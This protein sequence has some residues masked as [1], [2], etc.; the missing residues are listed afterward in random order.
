MPLD[1]LAT[2]CDLIAIPSVN[3]MGRAV[4]GS[5]YFEARLT[6]YLERLAGKFGFLAARQTVAPERDNYLIRID[7]EP[8]VEQ[9]G[10]L[11]LLEA[12]QDTVP[13][14]GMAI[15][16]FDPQ[17]RDGR[18]YG[19][20][21]C[22]N[23]GGLTSMLAALVRLAK[24]PIRSRP[25]VVLACTVNEE[26]GFTGAKAL[27]ELWNNAT[28]ERQGFRPP[29][30]NPL[31]E[32]EGANAIIPRRPDAA[33]VAEPTN[34]QIV[35]AHKGMVRWRCHTL[36]RASHSSRPEHGENAIFRMAQV[37]AVLERYQRDVVGTL[38]QHSL[39]GQPTLS[40]GTIN[41]G[42]SVNTVPDRC[43]IEIDRRLVPGEDPQAARQHVIDFVANQTRMANQVQHDPPMMR[44]PGLSDKN[45][46][47]VAARLQAAARTIT[48]RDE[49]A[50]GVSFGTDAAVIGAAGVPC[51]VFGPG[52]IEQAHTADEWVPLAEVEQASEALYRLIADWPAKDA[53]VNAEC[54]I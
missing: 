10:A 28:E 36:G 37:L 47:L 33:I 12:H 22:D 35:V 45:N 9:G 16:P 2:L 1:L 31:L 43:T 32:R 23:K 15:P 46:D 8:T 5:E 26:H 18:V 21:S 42:L 49:A 44:S 13:V 41:G 54:K 30:T 40:V 39:C 3:P 14:D 34:L 38:A 4:S 29:H 11:L 51:V 27:C 7:G 50:I 53:A 52:S 48:G 25:T 19:R 20:G 6:N 24:E 17:M